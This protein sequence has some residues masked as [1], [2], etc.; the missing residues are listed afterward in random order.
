MNAFCA[1][2]EHGR[3]QGYII[4]VSR[5]SD[6]ILLQKRMVLWFSGWSVTVFWLVGHEITA[7]ICIS[8]PQKSCGWLLDFLSYSYAF[9]E[10]LRKMQNT[11][12]V[13]F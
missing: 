5:F 8:D 7:T 11:Q 12:S 9:S 1:L 2:S 4:G 13:L 6:T 3:G 10:S